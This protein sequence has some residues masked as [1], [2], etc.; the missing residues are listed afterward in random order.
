MGTVKFTLSNIQIIIIYFINMAGPHNLSN[1]TLVPLV[2]TYIYY[3]KTHSPTISIC[4]IFF[5]SACV[6]YET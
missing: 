3:I 6:Q 2:R 5:V 4:F 1:Y